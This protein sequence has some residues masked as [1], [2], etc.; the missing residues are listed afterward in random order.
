[1]RAKLPYIVGGVVALLI[2]LRI[3]IH[4]ATPP[5]VDPQARIRQMFAEGKQAFE[6]EDVDALMAMVAHDFEW[7]GLNREQLRYQLANFFK[8]VQALRAEY[9]PPLIEVRGDRAIAQTEVRIVW[10]DIGTESQSTGPL[11]VEF[12]KERKRKWLIIPYEEWK[13]V[14]IR[15]L[16]PIWTE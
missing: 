1:M 14:K 9:T 8:N 10:G 7:S 12:R 3:G 5:P 11:E 15:G 6:G 13:V 16:E 4:F 2:A